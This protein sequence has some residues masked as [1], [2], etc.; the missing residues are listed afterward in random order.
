[1]CQIYPPGRP[2]PAQGATRRRPAALFD[3]PLIWLLPFYL[4][5]L[6]QGW[7]ETGPD[8]ALLL[9]GAAV[10]SLAGAL[11]LTFRPL[12]PPACLGRLLLAPAVFSLGWGLAGQALRP[13]SAPEHIFNFTRAAEP[14]EPVILGGFVREVTPERPG[15]RRLLVEA[16]EI[17]TPGPDGPLA[18]TRVSGLIRL[19]LGEPLAPAEV[20]AGDYVRLPV[21]PRCLSG[22]KNPGLPDSDKLWAGRGVRV[23]GSVKSPLLMTSWPLSL[24]NPSLAGRRRAGWELIRQNAP[25]PAAGLLAAQLLGARSV[26]EGKSEETFRRLGLS[27]ILSVSGLHLGLWYGLCFWLFRRGLLLCRPLRERGASGPAAAAL[28]VIPALFYAAL[29][30]TASPVLRAAVMIL[31]ATLALAARRRADPWNI[32][33]AAAWFILLAEP[34]RLFTASFQLSFAATGAMLAVF[35]P[36]PGAEPAP[37]VRPRVW[38]RPVGPILRRLLGFRPAAD[39]GRPRFQP[40]SFL[41]SALKAA[42]AGTLGTAPLVVLHFGFLPPAGIPANLIFTTVLSFLVLIPGLLALAVLPLSPGPAAGL[43]TW[44]GGVLTGLMPR[45][46]K[47]ADLAGPGLLLPAP[48][49][50]FILGWYGAGWLLTRGEGSLRRRLVRA[51]AVLLPALLP[52]LMAGQNQSNLMRFTV[53]DVGQG[54]AIHI[55]LPDGRQMLVDGGGGYDF[56]PGATVIRPYLLRQGLTRLDVV[57]L[58]HPDQDHLRGLVTIAEDF[59]PRE[60]WSAPWPTD[61]SPLYQAFGAASPGS[62]RPG[63]AELQRPSRF[64]PV[65]VE[66]L[67]PVAEAWPESLARGQVN[68]LGLVWRLAWGDVSFLITGDIGPAVEKDLA[69][70]HGQA[71]AAT[72]LLA[73]HHGGLNSLSPEF[74]AAVRPRWVVF[75]AGL[76]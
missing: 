37:P 40:P 20:A 65:K 58:T 66:L 64:G 33:A 48:G 61:F 21:T 72:V 69:A 55:A 67:W 36:R 44:A 14:A 54:T 17:I 18:E 38:N 70:R 23:R 3:R 30:G 24:G 41:Q 76:N 39:L 47:L 19:S 35:V 15:R 68:D 57:A 75:S 26:V 52:G 62:A 28:A 9:A 53:L 6:N 56:D 2:Q 4:A 27:H 71:L 51:G 1:M 46:E 32:L 45:M 42:L 8:P 73:P 25:E 13:P 29:A 10:L 5:G 63:W 22:L 31:A 59:R 16:R 12:K 11:A 49:P 74:L 34:G 50:I 60:I 7:A 43:M